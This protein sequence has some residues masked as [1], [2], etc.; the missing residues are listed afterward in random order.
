M[1]IHWGTGPKKI[2][3][4]GPFGR[5]CIPHPVSYIMIF[6]WPP[7]NAYIYNLLYE[8]RG[9]L[10]LY[11]MFGESWGSPQKVA[12]QKNR[13]ISNRVPFIHFELPG[14]LSGGPTEMNGPISD[15][16]GLK[17]CFSL[18]LKSRS[19]NYVYLYLYVSMYMWM[20]CNHRSAQPCL[21]TFFIV[22]R[23]VSPH[24][25]HAF[26]IDM[27]RHPHGIHPPVLYTFVIAIFR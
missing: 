23:R 16:V 13:Q 19:Y 9:D 21:H 11:F 1:Y 18:Y 7:L 25:F 3:I 12:R 2:Y 6:W 22:F 20:F 10:P 15:L 26:L 14:R 24:R 27:I 5:V 17:L 4:L 8:M